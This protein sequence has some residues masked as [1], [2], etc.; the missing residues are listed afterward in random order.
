[1]LVAGLRVSPAPAWD[2]RRTDLRA[3]V[4][5]LRA[6]PADAVVF[7]VGW[8]Q[9]PV[10]SLFSDRSFM[11][12]ERWDP[13]R[14]NALP[15]AVL[16]LDGAALYLGQDAIREVR[17][18]AELDPL[19]VRR[20]VAL[21]RLRRID[22]ERPLRQPALAEG[23]FDA[24]TVPQTPGAGWYPSVGGWAWVRPVSR[25]RFLRTDQTRLVIETA[26]WS[27]LF[28]PGRNVRHLHVV[29]AGCLDETVTVPGAGL[30][31][32]VLPLR[33]SPAAAPTPVE[34]SMMLDAAMPVPHQL[35]ADTR[36]RAFEIS[37]LALER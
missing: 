8:W 34:L 6:L 28:V 29:I 33:C 16:A 30:R 25:V 17:A 36:D 13:A 21:Y 14:I 9:A 32:L 31:R 37:R 23:G 15:Y 1:M 2:F 27:E 18:M 10:L 11:N 5:T 35:D 7:G 3:A 12:L 19:L 20:E 4:A 22:P 26:F 24:G